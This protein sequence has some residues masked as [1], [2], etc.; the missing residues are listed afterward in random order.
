MPGRLA[1]RWRLRLVDSLTGATAS[2]ASRLAGRTGRGLLLGAVAFWWGAVYVPRFVSLI[3]P[4]FLSPDA[5]PRHLHPDVEFNLVNVVSAIALLITAFLA[6]AN[7]LGGSESRIQAAGW[8]VLAATAALLAFEEVAEFKAVAESH[9]GP[10]VLGDAYRGHHWPLLASPLIVAFVLAMGVFLLKGL[11]ATKSA[12]E[13]R[14]LLLIG[15]T[16]WV[17]AVAHE[18][19]E[20]F[21]FGDHGRLARFTGRLLEETLEFGG[22]LVIGL[23][24]IIALQGAGVLRRAKDAGRRFGDRDGFGRWVSWLVA[25]T[26]VAC[27]AA[28]GI[29]GGYLQ[30][31]PLADASALTSTGAFQVSLFDERSLVQGL[32]ALP[33][34]P[35]QLR[36]RITNSDPLGRSG[37]VLWRVIYLDQPGTTGSDE[38]AVNPSNTPPSILRE[39]RKEIAAGD[40]PRWETI[41]F[42]PP[43]EAEGR[44]LA[45]QVIAEVA[46]EAHLRIGATKTDRYEGGRLWINGELTWPNENVEFV[47]HGAPELTRSKLRAMWSI[48]KSHW[49]WSVLAMDLVIAI[50]LTIY[51]PVILVTATVSR[52]SLPWRGQ[53]GE[54]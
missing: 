18:V 5:L 8:T 51:M 33:A 1:G 31:A 35:A 16:A 24:A 43:T 48:F 45:L 28:L 34:P 17:L 49:H 6:L 37:T 47:A 15:L 11:T 13:V 12:R 23:S 26:I 54:R 14:A 4:E 9:L 2:Q 50:T 44:P 19:T 29:V 42:P 30:K 7:V 38:P 32:G 10:M 22:T 46:P 39:G 25:S 3:F 40:H 27:M 41:E 21:L 53:T 52:R 36:L 20:D